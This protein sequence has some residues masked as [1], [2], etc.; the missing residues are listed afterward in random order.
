MSF[1]EE[2][3]Y[4]VIIVSTVSYPTAALF[5]SGKKSL[6]T[7]ENYHQEKNYIVI[8]YYGDD[9]YLEFKKGFKANE[10][11][12]FGHDDDPKLK[13]TQNGMVVINIQFE[14]LRNFSR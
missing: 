3:W 12:C 10:V 8:K 2:S 13:I 14:N 6:T 1:R 4:S 9:N 11:Y 5:A 7:T